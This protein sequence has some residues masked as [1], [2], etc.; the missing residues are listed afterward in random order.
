VG[1]RTDLEGRLVEI[2]AQ[3]LGRAREQ[4][5]VRDNFFELGGQ[6]LKAIQLL[7]RVR[8]HLH[9]EITLGTLLQAQTVADLARFL[10]DPTLPEILLPIRSPGAAHATLFLFHPAGGELLMYQTLVAALS[11]DIAVY[12]LQSQALIGPDPEAASLELMA[13]AY[14]AAISRQQGEGPSQMN[15][16]T[17]WPIWAWYLG[18]ICCRPLQ[19]SPL[20]NRIRCAAR[21]RRCLSQ[22]GSSR[23]WSG[24]RNAGFCQRHSLQRQ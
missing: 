21:C 10:Q 11:P 12:G 16:A 17:L 23:R 19:R 3:V 18:E 6:S 8:E 22:S 13:S 7:A 4:V 15:R 20:R 1:P 14:A 5:G 9:R 2:W 24:A